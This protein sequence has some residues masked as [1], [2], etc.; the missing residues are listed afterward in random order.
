MYN[1]LEDSKSRDFPD[2]EEA[3]D[4]PIF[5]AR[6]GHPESKV[7]HL[8]LVKDTSSKRNKQ[9]ALHDKLN[10]HKKVNKGI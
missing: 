10:K 7:G 3:K 4:D 5:E 8:E 1:S 6:V 9:E 2:F